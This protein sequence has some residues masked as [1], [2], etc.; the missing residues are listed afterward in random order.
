MKSPVPVLEWRVSVAERPIH[1][2]VD[3]TFLVRIPI[4]WPRDGEISH[5][6]GDRF[7]VSPAYSVKQRVA[8]NPTVCSDK[9]GKFVEKR[10]L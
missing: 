7:G 2:A 6:C 8:L 4:S 1:V 10:S 3:L 5:V 9:L